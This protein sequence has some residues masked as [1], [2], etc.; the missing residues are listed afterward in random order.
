MTGDQESVHNAL[1]SIFAASAA[2][3]DED[4]VDE[5][6][7]MVESIVDADD[8]RDEEVRAPEV[9]APGLVDAIAQ[10]DEYLDSLRRL[11]AEFE[12]YKKRV[13]KQQTDQRARAALLL[14]EK[15]LP[16]LDTL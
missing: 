6:E 2:D 1:D 13:D 5:E 12:N 9:A 14:V 10:R 7:E 11:Q 3:A 16:V 8:D 15:L 4:C